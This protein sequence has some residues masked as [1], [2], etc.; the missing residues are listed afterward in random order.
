LW[1]LKF[2]FKLAHAHLEALP[3]FKRVIAALVLLLAVS[4]IPAS[5]MT[6][7]VSNT[8]VFVN[9]NDVFLRDFYYNP[10]TQGNYL[11]VQSWGFGGTSHAPGG[12][13]A[14]GLVIPAGGFD[15]IVALWSGRS[16]ANPTLIASNDDGS[17]YPSGQATANGGYCWDSHML[18]TDLSA[19]WY[20][21]T[22]TNF[23]AFP[24]G[25]ALSLGFGAGNETFEGRT[26]R[27]ALDVVSGTQSEIVPEPATMAL[28]GIG[29]LA[30]GLL[31]RKLA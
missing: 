20:T 22:L 31:R 6:V 8:D 23:P 18:F 4:A 1:V 16:F 30:A 13:N 25:S 17:C 7:F 28:I 12:T 5:A 9:P 27:Y 14:S 11:N 15:P 26:N 2:K 29:L 3:V 10:A 21:V 24:S 19:G